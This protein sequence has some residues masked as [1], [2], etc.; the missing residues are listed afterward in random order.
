MKKRFITVAVAALALTNTPAAA[1]AVGGIS[2]LT[3]AN[4][5]AYSFGGWLQVNRITASVDLGHI[6]HE[7]DD[8]VHQRDRLQVVGLGAALGPVVLSGHY[9]QAKCAHTIDLYGASLWYEAFGV[10]VLRFEGETR[11]QAGIR[12]NL[13][14]GGSGSASASAS[15]RRVR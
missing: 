10:R 11:L 5:A 8:P 12:L 9:G 14:R 7:V 6:S 1:Q 2:A 13:G 15:R 3:G 4:D